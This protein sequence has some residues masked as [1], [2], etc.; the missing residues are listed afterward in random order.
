MGHLKIKI[1]NKGPKKEPKQQQQQQQKGGG[2][3]G[4]GGKQASDDPE[5]PDITHLDIRVGKIVHV[6]KHP[7]A[8]TL[9]VEQ[10]D[11]GESAPRTIVSGLVNFVPI[12]EMKD[13]LV[14]VLCN[15]KPK[16]TRGVTSHGMVLCASIGSHDDPTNGKVEPLDPPADSIPGTLIH[17]DGFTGF[18]PDDELNPK[19]KYFEKVQPDF[20][21]TS[22]RIAAYKDKPFLTPTGPCIVKSIVGGSI[23]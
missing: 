17:F 3:G 12:D 10:I 11:L 9:Y 2:K 23:K 7:N 21:T 13:R 1:N 5:Q 22:E 4:K 14:V 15:I 20:I 8:D 18:K 16:P 6:E 19:K